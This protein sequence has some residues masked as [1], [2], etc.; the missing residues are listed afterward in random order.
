MAEKHLVCEGAMCMCKFGAAPDKLKVLSHKKEYINDPD[1]SEKLLATTMEIG[2]TLEKN[3]FGACKKQKNNP[4]V[5]A[6]TEW[7]GFYT[8]VT[9]SNGGNPLLEDCK[10]TCPIGGAGC[11]EITFH[12]QVAE[13]GPQN[14]ENADDEVMAQLYPFGGL[15][16]NDE[17]LLSIN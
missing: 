13:M 11:I 16:N 14:D 2:T 1:G 7:K 5:A 10:A 9:L 17:N 15:K 8:E 4:C 12:G 3:T 6:I